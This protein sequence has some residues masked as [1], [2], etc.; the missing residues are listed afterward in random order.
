MSFLFSCHEN[1]S[2]EKDAVI[3]IEKNEIALDNIPIIENP[4][5]VEFYLSNFD[6]ADDLE[7]RRSLLKIGKV[8]RE[9]LK[10]K[11]FSKQI[12]ENA[13][14]NANHCMN[15]LKLSSNTK[16][17]SSDL[18]Y[19]EFMTLV[20][21]ANLKH[22]SNDSLKS[23]TIED[24]VPA[25]YMPNVEKADF[26][27]KPIFCSGIEVN[28]N[29][30]ELEKY[31][32]YIVAWYFDDNDVLKEI[33]INEETALNT[34][35]PVFIFDNAD[36]VMTKLSDS[37]ITTSQSM[38]YESLKSVNTIKSFSSYEYRIDYSYDNSNHSELWIVGLYVR[39]DGECWY[40][41]EED[42][43]DGSKIADVDEDDLGKILYKWMP[44]N[45]SSVNLEPFASTHVYFNLFER[46]WYGSLK[47]FGK[48][49]VNGANY[50]LCG[51]SSSSNQWYLYDPGQTIPEANLENTYQNWASWFISSKC[52]YRLWYCE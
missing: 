13:K 7:I 6:E 34:T 3:S 33:L 45:G 35:N 31:E 22:I 9:L 29:L 16:L 48:V 40:L 28:S 11:S 14:L 17:K 43:G 37:I 8:G 44:F 23:T 30:L 24:Y 39:D 38:R 26:N 25:I 51:N 15:L 41:K 32:D 12:I 18:K 42:G 49:T 27:K 1:E 47:R 20:Q 4:Y 5:D 50:Y 21:N 10:D 19:C 2:F 46:D 36:E 52:Q